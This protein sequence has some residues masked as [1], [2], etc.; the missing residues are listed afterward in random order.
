MVFG[1][2]T[3]TMVLASNRLYFLYKLPIDFQSTLLTFLMDVSVATAG[4]HLEYKRTTV[5]ALLNETNSTYISNWMLVW[6]LLLFT[7]NT[8][9]QISNI[10]HPRW[11]LKK[12]VSLPNQY[13]EPRKRPR[14]RLCDVQSRV[15]QVF[16]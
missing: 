1:R 8:K 10:W 13:Q 2:C 12:L 7:W 9:V 15:T 4:F 14:R 6:P 3:G 5:P 16:F 11:G